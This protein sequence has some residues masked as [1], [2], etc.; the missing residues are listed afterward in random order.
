MKKILTVLLFALLFALL[1]MG[2]K[3]GNTYTAAQRYNDSLRVYNTYKSEIALIK[4]IKPGEYQRWFD[5][6][7]MDDSL[8]AC[9][10]R[11]LQVYNKHTYEPV[12]TFEREGLGEAASY[13]APS[14]VKQTAEYVTTGHHFQFSAVDYQTRFITYCN[15]RTRI[16]YIVKFFY[17]NGQVLY[18][19]KL[20]PVTFEKLK[21]YDEPATASLQAGNSP[22]TQQTV[23]DKPQVAFIGR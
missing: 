9:A 23:N 16:P 10:K 14:V 3:A 17:D 22:E 11:R 7:A 15:G 2:L 18:S 8:A 20:D 6:Q 1:S 4:S 19:E 13:P 12:E 21:D 5:R